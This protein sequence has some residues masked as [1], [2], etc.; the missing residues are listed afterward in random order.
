[1]SSTESAAPVSPSLGRRLRR[2]GRFLLFLCTAG[3]AFPH[4]C[5]EDLDLTRIQNEHMAKKT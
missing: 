3:W 2:V 4:V 5:T 1:M